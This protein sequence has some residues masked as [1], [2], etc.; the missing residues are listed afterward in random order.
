MAGCTKIKHDGHQLLAIV[1]AGTQ[2]HQ[3]KRPRPC[4]CFAPSRK[5]AHRRVPP[6]ALDGEFAV[7]GEQR[8]SFWLMGGY[9]ST[10]RRCRCFID[11][12]F[13]PLLPKGLIRCYMGV[14]KVAGFRHQLLKR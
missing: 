1:A 3:P 7:P 6:L 11:Q 5:A 9:K 13:Q 4:P 8:P 2:T 10:L 14:D 12:A